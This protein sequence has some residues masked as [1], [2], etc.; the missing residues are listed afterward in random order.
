MPVG[1]RR[2]AQPMLPDG[3]D[4]GDKENNGPKEQQQNTHGSFFD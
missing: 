1:E 2:N 4:D 3:G